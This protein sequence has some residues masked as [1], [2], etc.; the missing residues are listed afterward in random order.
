MASLSGFLRAVRRMFGGTTSV[1]TVQVDPRSLG[2]VKL[3][4]APH[5]DRRPDPG[6][7]VWTWVPYEENDGRGKDR[8]VLIVSRRS[9]ATCLG[10]ALTSKSHDGD[11]GAVA[12]GSGAWDQS[13]RASWARID[14]L[15]VVHDG[16]MRREGAALDARR[17]GLVASGLK[18]RYRW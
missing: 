4:Y 6:E 14:R 15:F 10:V 2:R 12:L 16:G 8:P 5:A 11:R 13:G 18:A 1:A 9:E 17:Y 3:S 7:V